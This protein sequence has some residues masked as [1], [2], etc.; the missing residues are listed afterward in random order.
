MYGMEITKQSGQ[1]LRVFFASLKRFIIQVILQ[2]VLGTIFLGFVYALAIGPTA[3]LWRLTGS[4]PFSHGEHAGNGNWMAAS[5]YS[6]E[7]ASSLK[8]S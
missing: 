2:K 4:K 7:A 1:Y 5:G 3:I 8:Q 6:P